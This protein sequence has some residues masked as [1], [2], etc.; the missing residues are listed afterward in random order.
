MFSYPDEEAIDKAD[1]AQLRD[2][3]RTLPGPGRR[4]VGRADFNA[5]MERE[6]RLLSRIT[7]RLEDLHDE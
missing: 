4:A 5:V 7:R 3:R 2:W 6:E 1:A